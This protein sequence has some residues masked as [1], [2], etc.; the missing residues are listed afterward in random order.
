SSLAEKQQQERSG[1]SKD[2]QRAIITALWEKWPYNPQLF[3]RDLE[4]AGYILACGRDA[5][6]KSGKPQPPRY[7]VVDRAGETHALARQIA[8]VRTKEIKAYLAR[9]YPLDQL[10]DVEQAK[11][12]QLE[13]IAKIPD[14]REPEKTRQP[15]EPPR[16]T[17]AED[18][19][20]RQQ[21]RRAPLLAELTEADARH[22]K[23]RA[24]LAGLHLSE[25]RGILTERAMHQPGPLRA[26]VLRITGFSMLIGAKHRREDAARA[27]AQ[28]LQAE[29]LKGRHDR[30]LAD[31]ERRLSALDAIDARESLSLATALKREAFQRA[32]APHDRRDLIAEIGRMVEIEPDIIEPVATPPV[33]APEVKPA[34]TRA[35]PASTP[36][37]DD[38]RTPFG[39]L[40]GLFNLVRDTVVPPVKPEFQKAA[41]PV[42]EKPVDTCGDSALDRAR[43]AAAEIRRRE[44][45]HK[46][47][48]R[49]SG[50]D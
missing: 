13:A 8:G 47:R 7:V 29:A 6:E 37:R 40:K 45:E 38:T 2:R 16:D 33:S 25:N 23:E 15:Q 9:D 22:E 35:G 49:D 27:K 18:L 11:T 14:P 19:A 5:A 42:P 48:D 30:E 26:F 28:A 1:V 50:R 34:F 31:I 32:L 4:H 12:R 21:E 3:V 20:S 41:D 44:Q 24:A 17:R 43:R 36:A 46:S 39:K 10:P